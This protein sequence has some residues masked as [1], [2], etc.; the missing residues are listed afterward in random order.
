MSYQEDFEQWQ[1]AINNVPGNLFNITE[2]FVTIV[3]PMAYY[4]LN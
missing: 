1:N 2:F 4:Q 3:W